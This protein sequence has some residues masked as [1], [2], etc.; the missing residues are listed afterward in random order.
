MQPPWRPKPGDTVVRRPRQSEISPVHVHVERRTVSVRG[1]TSPMLLVYGFIG[2]IAI[3]TL[4]L[5]LPISNTSGGITPFTQALFTATSAVCVTGLVVVD[6]SEAWTRFGQ[7]VIMNLF[8]VGGLGFMTGAAFLVII[9]TQRISLQNRLIIREGI[10]GGQLDAVVTLVRN[11]VILAVI[12]QV[13]GA[14]LLFLSFY[15]FGELWEGIGFAEALWQSVFNS[16]SAFNNAGFEVM[17]NELVGGD[18]LIGL[19]SNYWALFVMG[20]LI[21]I[22]GISFAVIRD[23]TLH[24]RFSRFSLD[25]KLILVG[26][27]FLIVV[28]ASL[29]LIQGWNDPGTLGDRSAGEKVSDA[30]FDSAAARTAGFTTVD[31]GKVAHNRGVVTEMLMFV[32]GASASTAGGIKVNTFMVIVLAIA[33]TLRGRRHVRAFNREI[34]GVIVQRAMTVGAVATFAIAVIVTLFV[35]LQPELPFRSAVFEVVSAFGTVG[36]STGITDELNTAN[37]LLIVATMFIGRL[38]PLTL[39]LLMSGREVSEPYR[40]AEERVRIG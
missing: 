24:R 12:L 14:L 19:R 17:P 1:P 27:L 26:S 37:R 7:V 13:A 8:F 40:L 11:M 4:L 23:V 15:V 25:T 18:S 34:P 5:M 10:G 21:F 32:G 16:V 39:A 35:A 31:Y 28:G 20:L 9:V 30:L 6:T 2:L 3:G 38:G 22:G 29:F 33:A 36:L